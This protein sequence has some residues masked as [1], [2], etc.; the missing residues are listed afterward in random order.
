MY[1]L[2]HIAV[3]ERVI[4]FLIHIT[5]ILFH[6][7]LF[8][9]PKQNSQDIR[10]TSPIITDLTKLTL[11]SSDSG[12]ASGEQILKF[13]GKTWEKISAQPS[14]NVNLHSA[15]NLNSIFVS[16]KTEFQESKLFY[17]DGKEWESIYHPLANTINA[18]KFTDRNN[19]V[20]AGLGEIAFLRNNKWKFLSPLTSKVIV[21]VQIEND[22]TIWALP[23]SGTGLYKF[24]KNWQLIPQSDQ[25]HQITFH[26][27]NL[28]VVG[29]NF[30]GKIV[31]DST[32]IISFNDDLIKIISFAV[33]DDESVI[34]VGANGLILK[35]SNN[36][37]ENIRCPINSN[38]N[39]IKML[40][41]TEGWIVGD[42]GVILHYLNGKVLNLVA[43][44]WKGF[45]SKTFHRYAKVVDDE[46]GVV[47]ADFNNDGFV[48][49]FTCGLYEQNHLY[50]N[51][52]DINFDDEASERQ[53]S[54]HLDNDKEFREFNLGACAADFDNDGNI[55]LYVSSLNGLNKL[56]KNT[57][58]G[59]F[60]DYTSV[61]NVGGE[62]T[63]RTNSI[64]T[65]DVDNDG[66]LD[67][68]ITNENT[69][70][71]LFINNGAGIF[72]EV[73][74][75]VGLESTFG[76]TSCAFGDIDNDG[77]QDLYV[78]NWSD[79]NK[80]HSNQFIETSVLTFKDISS[81]ANVAGDNFTKSNGAVFSD[82]DNDADLDLF[83]TNR[84]TSNR[85]YQ[86]NGAGIFE[87][88][89]EELIGLDSLKSY[90]VVVKDY[91]GD[92]YKDIYVA[93][94]G[95]NKFFKSNNGKEFVESTNIYNA[96]I[97]G[98]STGIASADF[99]NDG[100]LDIYSANYIG[101]SSALLINKNNTKNN[102]VIRINGVSI[103]RSG[104]GTKIYTY[105]AGHIDDNK[106]LVNF[107]EINGGSG[108]GSMNE[109]KKIIPTL[110]HEGLDIKIVFPS[111]KIQIH[112]NIKP[113]TTLNISDEE[114]LRKHWIQTKH[115]IYR[116][117]F[118]GH[119]LFNLIKWFFVLGLILLSILWARKKY[120]SIP[121]LIVGSSIFILLNY[122]LLSSVFEYKEF[123]YSTLLPLGSTVTLLAVFHLFYDKIMLSKKVES[124]RLKFQEKISRDL[125]DDLASTLGSIS[126]YLE[127]LKQ[128]IENK[129][130]NIWMFF[131][132]SNN[133][134]SNAKQTITDLIWTIKPN[135]ELITNFTARI[136]E[137]YTEIFRERKIKFSVIDENIENKSFL[138][139]VEKHNIYLIVKE[140][141]NN[142][143]K[144]AEATEVSI[145]FTKN[146]EKINIEIYDDGFGFDSQQIGKRGNGL[147]N[148]VTRTEEINGNIIVKS[149]VQKG[150]KII[151]S[152]PK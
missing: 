136:R 4:I 89:T 144:H 34:A 75:K 39:D 10:T 35:Y 70:N 86:N 49:I 129:S 15:I 133:L 68:F 52:G 135:A 83:V 27:N 125:H 88:K 57:G 104:I 28:Y 85:L 138:S 36:K 114:G 118:D 79:E 33:L 76:G 60:V 134:L 71:R 131:N 80:L 45:I 140:A 146:Q 9:Q 20:I 5:I 92:G 25:V 61:A 65:A 72:S 143:I 47:T 77:D 107:S 110:D 22:S 128:A 37:W 108:Y 78:A 38:L 142:I 16:A 132:K 98:Y 1:E 122:Y 113:S 3:T 121:G 12:I 55:D 64:V 116:L 67:L 141:L 130:E 24:N 99:D 50:I 103:N 120:Y 18:M 54:G 42:E 53:V 46:Y 30:F 43:P 26:K 82:I 44:D 19:G 115:Y 111:S 95:E 101:A 126:I 137:N 149:E 148:M 51:Y 96:N 97:S 6:I 102:I 59:H 7:N 23:I 62:R 41:E 81:E 152:F 145:I 117:F 66:D 29:F 56:Y 109:F 2:L 13:D 93:N 147:T 32:H 123:I 48:D 106:Y 94:V 119:K 112:K 73:T 63:D 11:F 21:D 87:D 100:D 40:N 31:S 91:D 127:L 150:T 69:S 8:A 58:N 124:E 17:W 151:I 14:M 74:S 84:K 105:I 139:S 90:G